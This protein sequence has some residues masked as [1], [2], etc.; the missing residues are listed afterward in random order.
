M[1]SDVN[2]PFDKKAVFNQLEENDN[3]A[4]AIIDGKLQKRF[5]R[6]GSKTTLKMIKS[7]FLE[8]N[9]NTRFTF[10]LYFYLKSVSDHL[11]LLTDT[12]LTMMDEYEGDFDFQQIKEQIHELKQ[13][14]QDNQ[15]IIDLFK[16]VFDRKYFGEK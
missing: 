10:A 7:V 12:V 11:V 6:L 1:L 8:A 5:L 3:R 16:A 14:K 13:Q 2:E 15:D 4:L 9:A